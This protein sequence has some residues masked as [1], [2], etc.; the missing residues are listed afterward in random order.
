MVTKS[1]DK[2]LA[3]FRITTSFKPISAKAWNAFMSF[4]RLFGTMPKDE[5]RRIATNV[6]KLPA[7]L[8]Q[9]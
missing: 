6:G 5:A 9:K 4:L 3:V 7:L 2:V 1:A 8:R